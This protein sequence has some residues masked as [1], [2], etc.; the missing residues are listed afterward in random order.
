MGLFNNNKE[1]NDIEFVCDHCEHEFVDNDCQKIKY[2][3]IGNKYVML[4]KTNCPNCGELVRV[5]FTL[6]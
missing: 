5:E 6:K 1:T 3:I 2:P 4:Y